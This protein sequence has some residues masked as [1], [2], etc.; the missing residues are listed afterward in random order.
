MIVRAP[1]D[2]GQLRNDGAKLSAAAI[3]RASADSHWCGMADILHAGGP[4]DISDENAPLVPR[5]AASQE[6]SSTMPSIA[7]P[8]ATHSSRSKIQGCGW[9]LL[10]VAAAAAS[11]QVDVGSGLPP[12]V[13]LDANGSDARQIC[14]NETTSDEELCAFDVGPGGSCTQARWLSNYRIYFLGAYYLA[15]FLV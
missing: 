1:A 2:T 7:V 4:L 3:L 14:T 12:F 8:G 6:N 13:F 5:S 10:P 9:I 15:G 11:T